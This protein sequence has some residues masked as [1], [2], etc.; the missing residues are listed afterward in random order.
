MP[1]VQLAEIMP[2]VQLKKS[3]ENCFFLLFYISYL[4]A[5]DMLA[6]HCPHVAGLCPLLQPNHNV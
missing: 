6:T 1:T 2:T 5:E 4:Q 3:F